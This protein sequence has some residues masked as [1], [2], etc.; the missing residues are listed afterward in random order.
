ML[1]AKGEFQKV[2]IGEELADGWIVAGLSPETG[3]VFSVEPEANALKGAHAW[4]QGEEH[5]QNLRNAGH[6]NARQPSEAEFY[7]IYNNIVKGD[8]N[9][10]TKLDINTHGTGAS[11]PCGLYWASTQTRGFASSI[12]FQHI[13]GEHGA[14]L[15]R[16]DDTAHTRCIRSEPGLKLL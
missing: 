9:D 8:Q 15:R 10:Q 16:D 1:R 5:A 11:L 12:W 6:D 4:D 14:W 7:T 2:S 3:D 13:E